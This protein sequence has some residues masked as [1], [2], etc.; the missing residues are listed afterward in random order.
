MIVDKDTA[1]SYNATDLF[2]LENHQGKVYYVKGNDGKLYARFIEVESYVQTVTDTPKA[3]ESGSR[4]QVNKTNYNA[5]IGELMLLLLVIQT[6]TTVLYLARILTTA[7]TLMMT[8][9]FI[10][11]DLIRILKRK[12]IISN[13]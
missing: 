8:T 5:A 7:C 11:L 9:K 6:K 10:W 1:V 12:L 2:N 3:T 13:P 4:V